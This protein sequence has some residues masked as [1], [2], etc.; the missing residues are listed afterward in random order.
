[1][2][3]F[4]GYV[5]RKGGPAKAD[6]EKGWTQC[7]EWGVGWGGGEQHGTAAAK[8]QPVLSG[9]LLLVSLPRAHTRQPRTGGK[10]RTVSSP[11]CCCQSSSSPGY[12]L[13]SKLCGA[14]AD[15]Q[16]LIL[17]PLPPNC[18]EHRL[19]LPCWGTV[20]LLVSMKRLLKRASQIFRV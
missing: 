6:T 18:W 7:R 2:K 14:K 3:T 17:L 19:A 1:M 20:T 15:F 11:C 13:S 8:L 10:G 4:T 5:T 12:L 9:V 16:V